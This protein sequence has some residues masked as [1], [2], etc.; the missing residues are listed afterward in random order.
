M[1]LLLIIRCCCDVV[2][3]C[4]YVPLS[5]NIVFLYIISGSHDSCPGTYDTD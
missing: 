5:V 1:L 4:P 2:V 3:P